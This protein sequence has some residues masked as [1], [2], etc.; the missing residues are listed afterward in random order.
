MYVGKKRPGRPR[1][2]ESASDKKRAERA[3]IRAAGFREIRLSV[4]EE[5]KALF[6]RFCSE[7][8]LSQVD[9]LQYL[10]E[11]HYGYDFSDSTTRIASAHE[12]E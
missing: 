2:Y 10:L 9:A 12:N 6:D 5:C 4:P 11:L 7:N 1:L 8:K 3:R